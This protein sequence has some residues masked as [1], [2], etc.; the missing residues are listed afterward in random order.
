MP[1]FHHGHLSKYTLHDGSSQSN[2]FNIT[3]LALYLYK[4]LTYRKICFKG[5]G[6]RLLKQF[7]FFLD[8]V[9]KL[10]YSLSKISEN[11]NYSKSTPCLRTHI[12]VKYCSNL[13]FKTIFRILAKFPVQ[14]YLHINPIMSVS[15]TIAMQTHS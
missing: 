10:R 11:C 8:N 5:K 1:Q 13:I 14:W 3:I 6:L 2:N 9:Y 12:F 4:S 15:F 7:L